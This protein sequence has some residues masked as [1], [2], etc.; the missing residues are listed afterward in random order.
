MWYMLRQ[1]VNMCEPDSFQNLD[2]ISSTIISL[3]FLIGRA[4]IVSPNW[5]KESSREGRFVGELPRFCL[6]IDLCECFCMHEGLIFFPES[7]P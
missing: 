5:L 1:V 7:H 4:W 3:R 2:T 6:V